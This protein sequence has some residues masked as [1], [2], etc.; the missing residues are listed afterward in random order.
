MYILIV[1]E[2]PLGRALAAS[3]ISN[4]HEVAYI[5]RETEYAHMVAAE[6]GCL[7]I[8]GEPTNLRI[9]QEAG[10]ERAD[11]VVALLEKDSE[12][13]MVGL[14]ARQFRV[15]QILAR[16]RQQHYKAAYE[17]AGITQIFS[18]FNYL[19]NEL[20]IA[21]EEPEVRHVMELGN[22]QVEIAGI[23]VAANSPLVG[24]DLSALWEADKF[25][26]GAVVLGLL[27]TGEQSFHLPRDRRRI[28]PG[29]EVLVAAPH[30]DT[31]RIAAI[32]AN[33]RR[34]LLR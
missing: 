8:E 31:Q 27:K 30:D 19:H 4:G 23:E 14:F 12:N 6:L 20:M 15:P 22:G 10:V 32:V 21:I 5:D 9:L 25:P 29:D 17:L 33:R 28:D 3:L 24:K 1:N 18:A 26:P 16:L 2:Q 7:V 11:V 34:G 13:I